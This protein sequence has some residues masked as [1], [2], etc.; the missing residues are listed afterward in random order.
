MV[1][2]LLKRKRRGENRA[3]FLCAAIVAPTADRRLLYRQS[4]PPYR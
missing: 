4:V 3:V 1:G 2:T